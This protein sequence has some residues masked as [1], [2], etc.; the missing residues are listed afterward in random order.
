MAILRKPAKGSALL[1]R[2]Q[3]SALRRAAEQKAMQ[4]AKRRDGLRCMYPGCLYRTKDLPIDACHLRH[5]GMGGNPAVDRTRRDQ[6]ISLCRIHHGQL[7]AG[8][9]DITPLTPRGTD[10]PCSFLRVR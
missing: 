3:R 6:L 2:R 9:I 5:R 1:A 7:D 10:G 4:A 8:D